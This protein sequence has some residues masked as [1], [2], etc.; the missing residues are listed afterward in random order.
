MEDL[1]Q[2]RGHVLVYQVIIDHHHREVIQLVEVLI[3]AEVQIQDHQDHLVLDRQVLVHQDHPVH[4]D[5]QV[6]VDLLQDQALVHLAVHHHHLGEEE[7]KKM[8]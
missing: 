1:G 2:V 8:E 3:E 5:H 6:L 4:Q 7:D